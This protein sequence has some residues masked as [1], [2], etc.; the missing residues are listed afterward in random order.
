VFGEA[1]YHER[2]QGI[3][4]KDMNKKVDQCKEMSLG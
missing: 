2:E 1:F 3:K 4:N